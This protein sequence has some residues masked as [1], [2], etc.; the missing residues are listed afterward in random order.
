MAMGILTVQAAARQK[1][2]TRRP[3]SGRSRSGRLT[4]VRLAERY[5]VV[6]DS[7]FAEWEPDRAR[8]RGARKRW[9]QQARARRAHPDEL[10][11]RR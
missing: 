3:S 7:R 6:P 11:V 9:R 5:A 8:Q 10:A 4:S 2:T 1:R